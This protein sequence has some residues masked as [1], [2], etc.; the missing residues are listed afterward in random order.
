MIE[1]NRNLRK[2]NVQRSSARSNTS[3]NDV[4]N[5]I[6]SLVNFDARLLE[7]EMLSNACMEAVG[8]PFVVSEVEDSSTVEVR[9]DVEDTGRSTSSS[10]L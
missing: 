3:S 4:P 8:I 1:N 6:T 10:S 5:P 2:G 7:Y 9:D